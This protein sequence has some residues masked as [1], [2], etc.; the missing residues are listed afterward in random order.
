M[1]SGRRHSVGSVILC[2][3]D[4]RRLPG[5][6]L[7]DIDGQALLD[8]IVARVKRVPHPFVIATT[9]EPAEDPIAAHCT[10]RGYPVF[11]G[12]KEDVAGR[13]LA[14]ARTLGVDYASRVSGDNLFGD[15]RAT[16]AMYEHAASGEY[17]F[18]TNVTRPIRITPAGL[19]IELVKVDAFARAYA[20]YSDPA[21]HEHVTLWFYDAANLVAAGMRAY[22]HT[23]FPPTQIESFAVDTPEDLA[24]ARKLFATC[25]SELGA[26]PSWKT[27]DLLRIAAG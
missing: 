2:R 24:R 5:K 19:S 9:D 16:D 12:A 21:H 25:S 8:R 23:D 1:S 13:F 14:A 11:R 22:I 6:I 3:F 26:W 27:E 7:A 15:L 18:L 20:S 4:S 17:D 10:A